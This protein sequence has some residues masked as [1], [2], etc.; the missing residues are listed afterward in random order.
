MKLRMGKLGIVII[1]LLLEQVSATTGAN[2]KEDQKEAILKEL[3]EIWRKGGGWNP[4]RVQPLVERQKDQQIHSIVR[5]IMGGLKSLGVL[6]RKSKSLPSLNKAFDRNRLSGFLY[7]ISMYLQEMSAELDDRQ[8]PF[9]DDQFWGNLLYSLLQTGRETSLGIW[10]GK[11]PPRPTFRLQD[12][13]LSLR[14]SPHWDGLLGLVQSILTL[15]ERQPQKPILT[16]VSQNWKTISALLET[17]LQAVV[18][19]TY[20]QAVAGLQGFICVL[21]GRNDCAFNLSWLDQLISF[22]ETRNWKPVVS[23]HPVN[24]ENNQRDATLS[25]GRFKPFLVPP[26]VLLEEQLLLNKSGI[27]SESLA[28]MQALLLQALS[29]SNAGERAVQ[30]AERNPALLQGL[31][32]LRHGFLHNVGRSVYSNLRRKVSHMT[33]ALLDDVSSMVD[34]S[35]YSHHGRCSVGDLRQLILWGIRHNLTWNAQAMGFRSDGLPSMPSLM[36]CPSPE[37]ETRTLGPQPSSRRAK[38]HQSQPKVQEQ[39]D[40]IPSLSAEILEAACNA[41]IPGLTGVSNFTVF[42]YCNLFDGEDGSQDPEVN[43]YGA[44]LH[45]T[46]SDAAWYLSAAEEDFLWVHVCSEFFAHEF[47]KTV[48]ANSTFWLQHAHQVESTRDYHYLN[49]SSIDDLCLQL[50]NDVSGG[51]PPDATEDCLAL[52]SSKT[53]TA[54][55]FRRCFLPNN[56]ALIASLCGNESSQIPQDGSWAAEYC[57]KVPNHSHGVPKDNCDY[58][59][60]K[61]EQFLNSTTLKLCSSKAGLKDYICKN[62]TLYL[63]LVQKQ[64]SLLDYCLNSEESQGSKCVLQKLFDMLPAPYDFDTSQLCVNP[65]PILQDVIHKLTLCE[66]AMDERTGWLA[67]VSYVLRVLDFVVG[68]SAGLEEGEREVRQGLGQAI[69]LSSLQDNAS[70]WA[71]LR[72]D[73]SLSVLHTV[74]IFLKREQNSTLKEDLLSCFSPVLW[75]LIQREGNSS[76]LR[77][78][79]QE[80]LQMPR[81]SIRSVVLSAEKDAVKRFLSHVHQSWNQLQVETIQVSPK[82]QEAMETMTAA[83]IHKFPRVTPELF[84][85]L[86]QFIP[87]M[88]VSDIMTFPASLMV[89][90][91]VLMAIRDHSSEIKSPQKQAFVKRLLQS[92]EA[93]DVPSWPPLFLSSILPLLPHLPVSHF[94]LLTSQQLM[95]LIEMLGN[96][97][98]DATR[99][100]HVLRTVFSRGKNLTSDN[101]TRLGVLICYLNSEDLQQ[102]LSSSNLSPA[103]WQQLARCVSE[104]HVSGSGRL[105]HWLGTALKSLNAS[106]LSASAMASLHGM[107]PEMG[108]TF[109]EP[110]SSNE[111]LDLVTLPGMPTFPPA[112]AFQILNKIAEETNFSANTLC[113]LKPLFQG[114]G[115]SFLRKLVVPESTL[116]CRCWSLLLSDLQPAHRAMV[117]FA[118]QQAL[119]RSSANIT[120]QLQ[121][122]LPFISLKKLMS[123]LNGETVLQHISLY[124][125]MPWSHQQA[126]MLF[127]MIQRTVNITRQSL[128]DLGRIAGGMSCEWLKLWVNESGFSEL[129]QFITKLPGGLR[130]GLRK[131]I[132][133]ELRKRPDIDLNNLDPSFAARLPLTMMEHLSNSSLISVLDHVRQHFIDFLQLPR[134]KQMALA[135]KAINVLGI[136][137]DGLTGA[138]MDMLGPLLPFLDR[139]VLARMDREALKLRLEELKQYCLPS[140]TFRQISALLTEKSMLG[141]PKTWTVGDVEHVGRLLFTLSPQQIKSLPLGDLGRDT[142]EEVLMNQWR[143]KNSEV[144]KACSDLNGLQEKMNSVIH[145]IVKGRWW[146]R[147]GPIPSCADIKGTFPSAWRSYQLNRMKRKE[148][149]TCVEFIGQ[150]DTLDAEQREA[151]WMELRPVYKPVRQLKP[152]QVLELGCI[153]TE[154]GERELQAV[155]LSS[156]AVVAHLGN[157]NGWN[158]KKMRAVVLGIMKRLKR[159]PEELDVVELVSL[160]H[161][162]CGFSS[163]E[164][165]RLDP[166]NLSVAAL[167]LGE[168]VLPCSEQQTEALTSRLSSPLGFGPVSSWG[169]EVFTEIGTLAA[170]L[171]DMVLSALIKEQL[172]GL[173]PTAITLIPPRKMAVVF[174]ATQ[175]SWLSSEQACVVTEEQW[176]ELDS[177]QRQ[178]L[179]MAQYEGELM[180]EHR[181]RNQAPSLRFASSFTK[182]LLLFVCTLCILL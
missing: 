30:F 104:G 6:P 116:D 152:E 95:P 18:S 140:D 33:K 21:K 83:F 20:G 98:L 141:E 139:D 79:M 34:E 51:S 23:L 26:E 151:L 15:T 80:Y 16:F 138:F 170:G 90:E 48:C 8:Q 38:L 44:D 160:G 181:G 61:A 74:G 25:T 10:D 31:D 9:S 172:E 107:L 27:D 73:A 180:L 108:A 173:T 76:A 1:L 165:S 105:S 93:G 168:M 135:E 67:T 13:F 89:N 171:E 179:G 100:H 5:S 174:S 28:S 102:L 2:K 52:L 60:W 3:V 92:S 120:Q 164:I 12:L 155:N 66:G 177:E 54:Q 81:E 114:L 115:P 11:S 110:L 35:Q 62:A 128:L 167:F 94:Q 43:H 143:W 55:D 70:F 47:N 14:G 59:N 134:H 150:D 19:G 17:V 65:L 169:S 50:S 82:E 112:Q 91:S 29:R 106:I 64:P 101:I 39:S 72:P 157:L 121:C 42:L 77:F 178:A 88:S 153:V 32:N 156:L 122:L 175:L 149:K 86:S 96:S 161:L 103:L 159:K 125:H 85:D 124:K 142:V 4:Y 154:M 56:T 46:C 119:E 176:A 22:M 137:E 87:Y 97:S 123:D 148:L 131:C 63:T 40:S 130:P 126:Q 132:V 118:L 145:R 57:A 162:L 78:L 75:D 136:S 53:L 144:G 158:A 182:C 163:S 146:M 147:R 166:F 133:V 127:R 71:T 58:L 24:V 111:L 7:N 117:H 36:T 49:Q 41:S 37:E 68:L 84:I 113:R 45:A 129:L 69:L 109:L 99:G